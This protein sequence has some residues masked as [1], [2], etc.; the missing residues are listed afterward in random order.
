[1]IWYHT[2]WYK[3]NIIQDKV[4]QY[5]ASSARKGG[6]YGWRPSS[7]SDFSIRVSFSSSNLWIRYFRAY[8][9]IETRPTVPCRA[10]RGKSSDSR[11]RY[12]SQQ[13]PPPLSKVA[14]SS[15]TEP[16]ANLTPLPIKKRFLGNTTL[17]TNLVRR[18]LVM[19][20]GCRAASGPWFSKGKKG[21]GKRGKSQTS[22]LSTRGKMR[23]VFT[24]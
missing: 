23:C 9:F 22:K 20:I 1:M 13:Y 3:H 5:V 19:R 8:P 12:L 14:R 10:I 15:S 11:Q 4:I 21:D 18:N 6:W 17:G 24:S 2:I 7:S 16:L